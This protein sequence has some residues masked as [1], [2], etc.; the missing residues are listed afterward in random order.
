MVNFLSLRYYEG[1]SGLIDISNFWNK[2]WD[3]N[4]ALEG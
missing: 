2:E 4:I 1:S 3:L